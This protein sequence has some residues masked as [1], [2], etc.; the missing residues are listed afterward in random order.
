MVMS[1]AA[2]KYSHDPWR[3]FY[4]IMRSCYPN[5]YIFIGHLLRGTGSRESIHKVYNTRGQEMTPRQLI[6]FWQELDSDYVFECNEDQ[7]RRIRNHRGDLVHNDERFYSKDKDLNAYRELL[8]RNIREAEKKGDRELKRSAS[9][10]L[11]GVAGNG[12]LNVSVR[13]GNSRHFSTGLLYVGKNYS[14]GATYMF[15]PDINLYYELVVNNGY[16]EVS[17]FA[18]DINLYYDKPLL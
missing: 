2:L 4:E 18:P 9:D 13:I 8:I 17:T 3:A 7:D 11:R 12:F 10:E 15:A 5:G 6:D 14:K 16:T 1:M